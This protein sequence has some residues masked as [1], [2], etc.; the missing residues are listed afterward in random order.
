MTLH[1]L[2]PSQIE[3]RNLTLREEKHA[4]KP[5]IVGG[6]HKVGVAFVSG[7]RSG[8]STIVLLIALMAFILVA[9]AF[10]YRQL[11]LIQSVIKGERI[12]REEVI[13][14]ESFFFLGNLL[15][16]LLS[17]GVFI[18]F[19][20]WF[21]LAYCNLP[22]LGATKLAYT[23]GWAVV[24]FLVPVLNLETPYRIASQVWNGS[25]PDYLDAESW[26]SL[27]TPSIVK[28]WW[29]FWIARICFGWIIY[30]LMRTP[31]DE[32]GILSV[33]VI[34]VSNL[35]EFAVA[36][37]TLFLVNGVNKRQAIKSERLLNLC[38]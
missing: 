15:H 5:L 25:D 3:A 22:A 26:M 9:I 16:G 27:N 37:L 35:V 34:L 7:L 13:A 12:E 1:Q 8:R 10:N 32:T 19:L 23:Q 36:L 29:G 17:F 21:R 20:I 33:K 31:F 38:T 6:G 4:P 30:Q 18:S 14:I 28:W 2:K 24:G 11:D